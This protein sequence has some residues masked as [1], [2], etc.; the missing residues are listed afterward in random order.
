MKKFLLAATL[1]IAITSAAF[2]GGKKANAKLLSDLQT[3]LKTVNESA[4]QTK[5]FYKKATFTVNGTNAYA[6]VDAETGNLIGFGIAISADAL[7]EGTQENLTKKYQGWQ[8]SNSIMFIEESGNIA[9]YTQVA[10]GKNNLA[11]KVSP[12]GKLSIY[13]R[14]PN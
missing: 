3:A 8:V 13:A 1:L 12:K 2:A 7:P 10:K 4:W 14:M 6:Y 9:Y 11:L 5:E